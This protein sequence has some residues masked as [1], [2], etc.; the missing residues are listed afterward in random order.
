MFKT[1]SSILS[2]FILQLLISLQHDDRLLV[3][4]LLAATLHPTC[5]ATQGSASDPTTSGYLPDTKIHHSHLN[6]SPPVFVT[7]PSEFFLSLDGNLKDIHWFV[8]Q[9]SSV[10]KHCYFDETSC[11][12]CGNAT[13]HLF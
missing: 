4:L 5:P 8:G 13:N 7:P 11:T 3:L 10:D 2:L 12:D 1:L 6:C 9:T